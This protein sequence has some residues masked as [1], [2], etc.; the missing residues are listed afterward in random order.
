MRKKD[1]LKVIEQII[2]EQP[3]NKQEDLMRILNERGIE[4]TQAT[5]S[6]DIRE[7]RLGKI[8][9]NQGNYRYSLTS[10]A[11]EV[12][13]NQKLNNIFRDSVVKIVPCGNIL[14][15]KC[16]SGTGNAAAAYLDSLTIDAI[17]G[18]VGG[19]DTIFVAVKGDKAQEIADYLNEAISG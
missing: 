3:V 5:V 6:R 1:R 15:V 2:E 18:T 7:L 10:K 12:S 11:N 13:V 17:A 14:V 19:D 9:D 8:L 16:H 4:V